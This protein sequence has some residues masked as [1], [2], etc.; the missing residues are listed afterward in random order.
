MVSHNRTVIGTG[1]LEKDDLPGHR[2]I[3]IDLVDGSHRTYQHGE[4]YQVGFRPYPQLILDP[5][6][7]DVI[8]C[9]KG[10]GVHEGFGSIVELAVDTAHPN[11][12][13]DV[14]IVQ[15]SPPEP[16]KGPE[17]RWILGD[18]LDL[19]RGIDIAVRGFQ[20]GG[21]VDII[22]DGVSG[23]QGI[24]GRVVRSGGVSPEVEG[25]IQGTGFIP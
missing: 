7:D 2:R 19:R 15:C 10:R 18:D 22:G 20:P 21:K 9:R 16:E 11:I 24:L 14:P 12:P 3:G 4:V 13:G 5:E 1:P 17:D 8:P 25:C 23:T 6:G